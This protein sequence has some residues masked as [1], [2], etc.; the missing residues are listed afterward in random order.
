[1][2]DYASSIKEFKIL[3]E[4]SKETSFWGVSALALFWN[5]VHLGDAEEASRIFQRV[6]KL[7]SFEEE[8]TLIQWLNAEIIFSE[9][10]VADALPYYFNI[11]NTR[12][13]EKA[14]FRIGKGY[15]LENKFREAVTNLDIL[16]L[17]FPNSQ[18]LEEP[19]FIKG[20]CLV[21]LGNPDQALETLNLVVRQ[22]G[23][24]PWQV[25]ALT[26]LGM[27]HLSREENDRA[28]K[29]FKRLIQEFPNHP[30]SYHAALQLGNLYFKKKDIVEAVSHY[31]MVLK[32]NILDLL[33]EASFGLGEIFYQ[34]G[35]YDKALTSFETGIRHLKVDSLWFFL[36]QLEIGNL[37]KN[38]GKYEEA[39]KSYR[40]V[41]D[42]SKDEE[43]RK[44]A[45]ELLDHVISD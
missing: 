21:R 17:E 2:G 4:Q 6:Q 22:N 35:K 11:L 41:L 33:G 32:G 36:T 27:I 14:L 8:R 31:S 12:F 19:L 10:R 18:Y 24:R 43:V 42:H 9:G 28:E 5:Y 20:E 29:A 23:N 38:W 3:F 25:L 16:L 15:F 39:K 7:N 40:I 26:Q 13:R 30:L 45:K 34:Q 1:M 44:A 37:Q